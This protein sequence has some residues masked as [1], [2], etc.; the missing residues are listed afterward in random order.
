MVRK[1]VRSCLLG[2]GCLVLACQEPSG[3]GPM[4]S[5][6]EGRVLEPATLSEIAV[7]IT[8]GGAKLNSSSHGTY[9]ATVRALGTTHGGSGS[10]RIITKN[11]PAVDPGIFCSASL[12]NCD[13]SLV[14]GFEVESPGPGKGKIWD[15]VSELK[16]NRSSGQQCTYE[17]VL[18]HSDSNGDTFFDTV[19]RDQTLQVSFPLGSGCGTTSWTGKHPKPSPPLTVS[20]SA[21]STVALGQTFSI[22][23]TPAGGF[24]SYLFVRNFNAGSNPS[25]VDFSGQ[26]FGPTSSWTHSYSTAGTFKIAVAVKDQ[27]SVGGN[28]ALAT[29]TI[30]VIQ[31]PDDAEAVVNSVIL[32][33]FRCPG[34]IRT[35]IFRMENTGAST[36]TTAQNYRLDLHRDAGWRP[37]SV[38][39]TSSVPPGSEHAFTFNLQ[40]PT[41]TGTFACF[42]RMIRTGSGFFGEE[43]GASSVT[44]SNS[45]CG[46]FLTTAP[47]EAAALVGD[48]VRKW[49]VSSRRSSEYPL[50]LLFDQSNK[51]LGVIN[52]SHGSTED[53]PID[54]VMR[55]EYDPAF[56]RPAAVAQH[57]DRIDLHHEAGVRAPGEYW[58]RLH[59]NVQ[60]GTGLLAQIPFIRLTEETPK[61]W[62]TITIFE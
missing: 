3:S 2:L 8:V 12:P 24:G 52:Y 41:Q 60:A 7:V 47:T 20:I 1:T 61:R 42:Y 46:G 43:N 17:V 11:P 59:G 14:D 35:E 27:G 22:T 62:G 54:V 39:V 34:E 19:P 21:P 16:I 33:R 9:S 30:E 44:I 40:A 56:L 50:L 6:P 4:S 55:I 29:R 23:A 26:T 32:D 31:N 10:N 13:L 58:V 37:L 18:N 57:P 51:Q 38:P 48:P 28:Y 25:Q 49:G 36:W 45:A 5:Q 53:R 15:G